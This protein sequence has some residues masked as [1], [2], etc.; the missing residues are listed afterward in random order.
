[1]LED[2]PGVGKTLIAQ[3]IAKSIA[4]DFRRIQFTPDLL[5]ADITGSSVYDTVSKAFHFV[6][7][8]IFAHIVLADEINR[9]TPRTQSAM[10]EAMNER[11]VSVDGTTYPLPNPFM[12]IATENPMEFE[13]TYPLPESQLDRFLLRI[14]VGYPDRQNELHVLKTHQ[15]S[16]PIDALQPVLSAEQI[17]E[18]Q[19]AVSA[20]RVDD[21]INQYILDI[22]DATRNHEDLLVG[23]S[24][25]GAIALS[26]AAQSQAL[27]EGRNFAVPDDV[28]SLA[29]P[30][31]AHRI[32]P[33]SILHSNQRRM[34]ES[35]IERI[36]ETITVP[37]A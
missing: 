30:V 19:R 29:V 34:E 27:L 35:I 17:V 3:A 33:K 12:V 9:T 10:L 31:L 13:G 32:V 8:A 7:G 37:V 26:R 28:K 1:L 14:S 25:R 11:Q 23:V 24:T 2:V 36:L 21:S 16:R 5:P 20:V 18:I 6:R 4:G 15:T 22:A